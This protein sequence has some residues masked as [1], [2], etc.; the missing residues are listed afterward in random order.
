LT[1]LRPGIL[2]ENITLAQVVKILVSIY[3]RGAE[4]LDARTSRLLHFALRRLEFSYPSLISP[5]YYVTRR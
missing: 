5:K 2:L 1:K 3:K 4:T